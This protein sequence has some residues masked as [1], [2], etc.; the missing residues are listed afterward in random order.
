MKAK[1][2]T[3][4]LRGVIA[5][6]AMMCASLLMS[7][8]AEAASPVYSPYKIDGAY[9]VGSTATYSTSTAKFASA[10]TS[11]IANS[12][13]TVSVRGYYYLYGNLYPTGSN[14]YAGYTDP[15]VT[16][17]VN[18][19][20]DPAPCGSIGSHAVYGSSGSWSGQSS[21]GIT[22]AKN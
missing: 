6:V 15:Y 22:G 4:K 10:T 16:V 9:V 14:S 3:K 21:V 17:S 11:H 2:G 1:K 19:P 13:K 20:S 8:P 5:A 12:T 18:C 7:V